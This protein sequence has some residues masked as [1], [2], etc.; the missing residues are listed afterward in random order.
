M[1][2][3]VIAAFSIVLFVLSVGEIVSIKTKAF[4]PSV[5][6][7]AV[8]FL[9]GFWTFL[10]QELMDMASFG[11]TFVQLAM[12]LLLVHMGKLMSVKELAE[13]WKKVLIGCAGLIGI[14]LTTLTIG[15]FLFGWET[16]VVGTPPLTGGVVA[17]LIMSQAASAKGL[18]SLS[19][20][21]ISMY[22]MQGFVGYPITAFCLKKEAKR[23]AAKY[24][25]GSIKKAAKE[26]AA[27]TE[28]NK[29]IPPL[30]EKYQTSYVILLKLGLVAWLAVGFA[31]LINGV[32]SKYVICL[33]FGVIACET[34]FLEKRSLNKANSFGWLMTALMAFI[35]AQLAKATPSML[36]KIVLPLFGTIILG[37]SGMALFSI[38][39]GKLFGYTKEMAFAITLTALFGFPANYIL[40]L[41]AVKS[42]SQTEEENEYLL[43]NMVPQMLV[44]G[45]TTVTIASVIIAGFFVNLL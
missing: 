37:I 2:L 15:R 35:F 26:V 5:F 27:T 45:F 24:R 12:Y 10:P 40:T 25:S 28:S 9:V 36:A 3:S 22:V 43:D 13:Q 4:V 29:L 44:G 41:E 32:I 1:N 39:V 21:A 14:C 6:V 7:S 31:G 38:I 18:E 19:V 30:P 42:I 33:V 23:L 34:G 16:V 11:M 17:S 20:L 8:L